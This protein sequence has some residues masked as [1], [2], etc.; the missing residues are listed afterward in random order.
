MGKKLK[1]IICFSLF[2]LFAVTF[3]IF[4]EEATAEPYSMDGECGPNLQWSMTEDGELTITGTGEMTETPWRDPD[5]TV[6]TQVK[7]IYLTEGITS[8]CREAFDTTLI[9]E[10]TLPDSLIEIKTYAFA[11]CKNLKRVYMGD[12]VKNIGTGAF[13]SCEKLEK[14]CWG[15]R[16]ERIGESAFEGCDALKRVYIPKRVKTIGKDAFY[17]CERLIKI[18][19]PE[20]LQEIGE[21]AFAHCDSLKMLTIPKTVK[22]IG[23]RIIWESSCLR[24]VVNYSKEPVELPECGEGFYVNVVWRVNGKPA[25]EVKKNQKAK[26]KP[27][28]YPIVYNLRGGHVKGNLPKSYLYGAV[29]KLPKKAYKKGYVFYG[30]MY[31]GPRGDLGT[32]ADAIYTSAG[33]KILV[34]PGFARFQLKNAGKSR[35]KVNVDIRKACYNNQVQIRYADNKEMKN[36]V[37]LEVDSDDAYG[38]V[39][40]PKFEAGKRYWFQFRGV[41]DLGEWYNVWGPKKSILVK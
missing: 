3:A 29:V 26:G 20:G 28:R 1:S 39:T 16:V 35:I 12:G 37:K 11:H 34:E 15:N 7:K 23:K 40:T 38:T 19:L 10:V 6:M 18:K 41:E 32:N 14:V 25:K 31:E 13:S 22:K 24:K 36:A 4:E 21:S 5:I 33:G 17:G 30:W 8:I 9:T 2:V 27:K